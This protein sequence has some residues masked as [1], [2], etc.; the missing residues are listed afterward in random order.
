MYM[1][2]YIYIYTHMITQQIPKNS[3]FWHVTTSHNTKHDQFCGS[4][5]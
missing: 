1:D 4:I 2:M 3:L 5:R